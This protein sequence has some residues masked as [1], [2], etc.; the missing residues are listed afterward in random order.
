MA[1]NGVAIFDDQ[2]APGDDI[3]KEASSFD[4][5]QGHPQQ[6]GVYHYHGEP[7]AITHDDDRFV[8]VLRDGNPVYGRRDPDGTVPSSLDASG[9]HTGVTTDS[10][11]T[12]VYHYHVNL[13]TSTAS[14]TA[15]EQQWFL[16]T[17]QYHN[18]PN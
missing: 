4:Q 2:A 16:T 8:G 1:V 9:G 15:G 18:A 11:S 5:C 3:F 13:Q 17:G 14:G 12:P 10:P 6:Q 7:W